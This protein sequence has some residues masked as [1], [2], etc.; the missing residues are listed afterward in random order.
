MRLYLRVTEGP[1]NGREAMIEAGE[2]LIVG[3]ASEA[4]MFLGGDAELSRLHFSIIPHEGTFAVKDLN[5]ANGTELNGEEIQWARLKDG[6]RI[7]AGLTGFTVFV[8]GILGARI[9]HWTRRFSLCSP[10]PRPP[11]IA[12]KKIWTSV[13]PFERLSSW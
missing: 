11:F 2:S 7:M 10:P 6:D 13:P 3:R 1:E 5:S 12:R 8:E 9:V 4:S